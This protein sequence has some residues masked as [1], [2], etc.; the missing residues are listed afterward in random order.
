MWQEWTL[1]SG[2]TL[3]FDIMATV[4]TYNA[5]TLAADVGTL[6]LK[7]DVLIA[8]YTSGISASFI[9][10]VDDSFIGPIRVW[11]VPVIRFSRRPVLAKT[12]SAPSPLVAR[13]W[14]QD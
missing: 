4:L 6:S 7:N 13:T 8:P 5:S 11:G 14:C 2:N 10:A 9:N 3:G 1:S 12:A